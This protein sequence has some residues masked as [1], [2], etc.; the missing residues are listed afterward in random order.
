LAQNSGKGQAL[1]LGVLRAVGVYIITLD[2]DLPYAPENVLDA[3]RRLRTGA[4]VAIG[5]RTL[6]ESRLLIR[7]SGLRRF[8]GQVLSK[9]LAMSIFRNKRLPD[10]QCGIKGY[11]REVALELFSHLTTFGFGCD[12]DLLWQAVHHDFR[13]ERFPVTL[14]S[15]GHTRVAILRDSWHILK[16]VYRLAHQ[17]KHDYAF[18]YA[19]YDGGYQQRALQSSNPMQRFWHQKK[20]LLMD[21][22]LRPTESLTVYDVG[23]GSGNLVFHWAHRVRSIIGFD[24]AET[25]LDFC[26]QEQIRRQVPNVSFVALNHEHI[27]APDHSA[28]I[29]ILADVIE[30]LD[31][32]QADTLI[33]EIARILKPDGRLFLTTPNTKSA[34][35]VVEYLLDRWHRVPALA[36]EQHINM[37]DQQR[38]Q[39]MLV[40][41]DFRVE[42]IGTAMHL[43][44]F[45]SLLSCSFAEWL[46]QRELAQRWP[47]GMLLYVIAKK[48]VVSPQSP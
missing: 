9:I 3:L 37:F 5:D 38:L 16:T 6:P 45:I 29:V 2:G 23:C 13:I 34:W 40:N 4:D 8:S 12:I 26:R 17:P 33:G 41:A 47:A 46:F 44:P 20:L 42:I 7:P 18:D 19:S 30:H 28:D 25:V 36:H 14:Q 22:T 21:K 35:P 15:N 11:R 43:S 48:R 1:L 10:T 39:T 27:S 31:H 24:V 32:R